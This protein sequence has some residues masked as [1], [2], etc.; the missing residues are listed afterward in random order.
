MPWCLGLCYLVGTPVS[1]CY[2]S[3]YW[4][5]IN[6]QYECQSNGDDITLSK[7]YNPQIVVHIFIY[8]DC[9]VSSCTT[10]WC[11]WLNYCKHLLHKVFCYDIYSPCLNTSADATRDKKTLRYSNASLPYCLFLTEHTL[12]TI[13]CS[14]WFHFYSLYAETSFQSK[15]HNERWRLNFYCHTKPNISVALSLVALTDSVSP[16]GNVLANAYTIQ[17]RLKLLYRYII[18]SH[19]NKAKCT[20]YY[21]HTLLFRH[22][23]W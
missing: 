14:F 5:P 1:T 11:K 23:I 20:S 6:C 13:F 4:S 12:F 2:Q 8:W 18:S 21:I 17:W 3:W 19:Q 10:Q 16:V 22:K 9:G 15:T 7:I